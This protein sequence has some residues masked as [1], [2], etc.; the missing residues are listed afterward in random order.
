MSQRKYNRI[1]ENYQK[2]L[3]A[4]LYKM[5]IIIKHFKVAEDWTKETDEAIKVLNLNW[6]KL[7]FKNKVT[8]VYYPLFRREVAIIKTRLIL[9]SVYGAIASTEDISKCKS[10]EPEDKAIEIIIENKYNLW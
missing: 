10:E 5:L 1:Q 2:K 7:C 8:Q 4:L 3:K 6:K 9:E